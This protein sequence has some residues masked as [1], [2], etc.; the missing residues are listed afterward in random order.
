ML[1]IKVQIEKRSP[2]QQINSSPGI[3]S[4]TVVPEIQ[5]PA[6]R[7][8]L[9]GMQNM[10]EHCCVEPISKVGLALPEEATH[11]GQVAVRKRDGELPARVS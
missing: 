6:A 10:Q 8:L 11:A 3:S 5:R 9:L 7:A 1:T 4:A 2:K